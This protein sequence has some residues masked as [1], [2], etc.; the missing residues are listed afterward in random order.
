MKH[1]EGCLSAR[2]DQ[3]SNFHTCGSTVKLVQACLCTGKT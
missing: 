3:D 2:E 1:V